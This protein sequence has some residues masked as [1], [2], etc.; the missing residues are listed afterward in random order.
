MRSAEG[1]RTL[2]A[3]PPSA[4]PS[5]RQHPV[6]GGAK[7]SAVRLQSILVLTA[8]LLNLSGAIISKFIAVTI[9]TRLCLALALCPLLAAT[10]LGRL[11]FWVTAGRRFQLS[12]IYP[13]LSINYFFSFI[14]GILIFAETFEWSRL[15]GSFL[16]VAGV[17]C[18][19]QSEHQF[20]ST[21]VGG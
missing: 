20:E 7:C 3:G 2:D 17:M 19:M 16:I 1:D 9:T 5:S 4:Q 15:I 8:L 6:A 21:H 12:Y 11:F 10:H 13:V 14:L 18:I